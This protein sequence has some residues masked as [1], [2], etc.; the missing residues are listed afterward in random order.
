ME[1]SILCSYGLHHSVTEGVPICKCRWLLRKEHI[2]S[3]AEDSSSV[4]FACI[5]QLK[6]T[7][8]SRFWLWAGPEIFED[9]LLYT[10][11]T[12]PYIYSHTEIHKYSLFYFYNV[13]Y[14]YALKTDHLVLDSQLINKL[15][16]DTVFFHVQ[17][18]SVAYI[19]LYRGVNTLKDNNIRSRRKGKLL[20][21]LNLCM[22]YL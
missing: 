5:K 9:T 22:Q 17:H 11:H 2:A 16:S 12:S 7:F 20:P 3:P 8:N 18:S 14:M 19:S 1:S 6:I 4:P 13:T 15:L 21:A 10:D